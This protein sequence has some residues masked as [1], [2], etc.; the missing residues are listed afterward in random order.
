MATTT[1][2][3]S[4][5]GAQSST[6]AMS[7]TSA[8]GVGEG[9]AVGAGGSGG[10]T[11]AG[12]SGPTCPGFAVQDPN[13]LRCYHYEATARTWDAQR[14]DCQN[15]GAGWDLAAVTTAAERNFLDAQVLTTGVAWI[16]GRD[17]TMTDTY[18]WVTG[19]A[20][21]FAPWEAG[22]PNGGIEDCVELVEKASGGTNDAFRDNPCSDTVAG[23]CE[24]PPS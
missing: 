9:G 23:I 22:D 1:D 12:G 18:E 8:G 15:H 10:S 6:G 14:T 21:S 4:G 5:G 16:A 2:D 17:V 11:G 20:W 7:T 24:G 13:S 19:E 3:G